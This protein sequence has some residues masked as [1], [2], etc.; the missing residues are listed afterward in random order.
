M[1]R[2]LLALL[3]LASTAQLA[4][5]LPNVGQKPGLNKTAAGCSQTTAVIDL[6]VNNVRA[7]LMNGGDMWWDIPTANASYEVP[8]GSGKNALF[9]GSIWIGGIDQASNQLKV[10]AQTY[11]QT[12]NDYWSG[13]LDNIGSVSFQTCAE[14]DRFWKINASDISI[15]R[16]LYN[17]NG[18]QGQIQL[19]IANNISSV[20]D[21]IKEWPAKGNVDAKGTGGSLLSSPITKSMAPFVDVDGL[22]GYNWRNGDYPEILGDQYIWWVFNDKGDAKTETGS[23]AIGLEIHA[24][25][26]AFAT[27]NCLNDATFY[28]YKIYN[29]STSQLDSTFMATWCDA[30]LGYAFD[31][32]VGCDVARGLGILYNGDGFDDGA[33]GYGFDIPMVGVDYFQGPKYKVNGKDSEL[34]MTVFTYYNNVQNTPTGNPSVLDD[35][36]GFI[37]GTWKDGQVYTDKCNARDAGNATKFIFTGDPCRGGWSEASCNNPPDDRRFIHSAGP[38]PLIPGSEPNNI[39]IGAIWVPNVG[40]GKAA[41]FGKIQVCD[42]IAQEL[43]TAQF[44]L[45]FGPNAPQAN[46]QPLDKKLVFD[47][48]NIEN[49]NNYAEA[50]GSYIF[51]DRPKTREPIT[52]AINLGSNDTLYQFEGYVVYQLKNA[53]VSV[54]EIRSKDGSINTDVARIAFQCDKKNGIKSLFNY[55]PDPEIDPGFYIPKKMVEGKDEGIQKSFQLTQDLFAT[56]TSKT[57]VNYKTYY[58]VA[59]AYAYNNFRQFSASM[60]DSTQKYQYLESRT[61]GSEE[62]IQIIEAMP[63]PANDSLYIQTY[64]EYG[65]GIEIKRIEGKGNGGNFLSLTEASEMEAVLGADFHSKQPVYQGNAGPMI[66]KV[67]NPDSLKA[68]QYEIR[69]KVDSFYTATTDTSKGIL[70]DYGRWMIIKDAGTASPDT[71]WSDVAL[72]GPELNEKYLRKYNQFD[73]GIVAGATQYERPGDNKNG[74]GIENGL[75][76]STVVYDDLTKP[77]LGGVQDR[78]GKSFQNWIRSGSEFQTSTDGSVNDCSMIDYD[79][80]LDQD[81]NPELNNADIQNN[82]EKV[83]GGTWAPYNLVS[84]EQ[85]NKCGYGLQKAP[86]YRNLTRLQDVPS[87]DVVFTSDRKMWSRCAVVELTDNGDNNSS[88]A[89]GGCFKLCKRLHE[90]WN[91]NVDANGAPVYSSDAGD[92]GMSYFPGYAINLETGERLNLFFGESSADIR[93]NGRDMIWN[94]TSELRDLTTGEYFFGGKHAVYVSRTKYDGCSFIKDRLNSA[95]NTYVA[96]TDFRDVFSTI[97]WCGFPMLAP[98]Q[99]YTTLK[100]GLIP[101]KTRVSIRV[102]RPYN[103]YM[104]DWTATPQNDG[105]PLYTFNTTNLAP[106]IIGDGRNSFSNNKDEIFKRIQAVPNPYYAISEYERNKLDNRVRIINLP[107]QASIK[108]YTLDGILIRTIVKNDAK[109]NYVDW[110]L[111]NNQ[112]VP[113]ASGMYILHITLPGIGETTL[114]WFGAMRPTDITSF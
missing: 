44:K 55:D 49:S 98:G 65:T 72:R 76:G 71:V 2:I 114:K 23:D 26:F 41:C 68:G 36:Y 69:F 31:D 30:D 80:G 53:D 102:T 109:T 85:A 25:A 63:H 105:W 51:P 60:A 91:G 86:G 18:S 11:R 103:R 97:V 56:G 83:I 59:I 27:N 87:I 73:W 75:I 108:V 111:K 20:P 54:A 106:A 3:G 70:P 47:L 17:E 94:P 35:F 10:A 84:S 28:N 16:G 79:N 113:I 12:G 88:I 90:G 9:A 38:F 58:Y 6:D 93:N 8:K 104:A 107:T 96:N 66:L 24:A 14:W 33:Q 1:K 15:F 57:L 39:T 78:D 22:D 89:E 43:F 40:G 13:P 82:Y 99:Q 100:D 46:V 4:H 74:V 48:D 45:P 101:T 77:W 37:T 50:Y 110:D 21:I 64:A 34:K 92:Y 112:F 32:Y 19:D 42:D 62:P 29:Y 52:K 7:R 5:A 67:V 81:N 95:G 61:N